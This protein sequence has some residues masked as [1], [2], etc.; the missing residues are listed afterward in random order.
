MLELVENSHLFLQ[1][2]GKTCASLGKNKSSDSAIGWETIA[3]QARGGER[4]GDFIYYLHCGLPEDLLPWIRHSAITKQ[5]L[6]RAV[7]LAYSR[8]ICNDCGLAYNNQSG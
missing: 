4:L 8:Q 2:V 5:K 3:V 6:R 1:A 7:I